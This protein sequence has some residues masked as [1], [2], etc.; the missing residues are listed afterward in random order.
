MTPLLT[1]L[2]LKNAVKVS[3]HD[4][5]NLIILNKLENF[6]F[7]KKNL[8]LFDAIFTNEKPLSWTC[9]FVPKTNRIFGF[10]VIIQ[11]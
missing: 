2:F 6:F 9:F 4:F 11:F 5:V 1:K 3:T 8:K 10:S 7:F